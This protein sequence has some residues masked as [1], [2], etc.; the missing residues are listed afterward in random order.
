MP[1][2]ATA[3]LTGTI[4]LPLSPSSTGCGVSVPAASHWAHHPRCLKILQHE[5]EVVD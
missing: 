4:S 1:D 5:L 2:A 3:S